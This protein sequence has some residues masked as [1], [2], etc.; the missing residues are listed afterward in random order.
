MERA[1]TIRRLHQPQQICPICGSDLG[2]AERRHPLV[3]ELREEQ[4]LRWSQRICLGI[5]VV[6]SVVGWALWWVFR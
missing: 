6:V 4:R 2:P 3:E 5:I 1:I